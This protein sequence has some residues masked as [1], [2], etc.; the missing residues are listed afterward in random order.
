GPGD[1]IFGLTREGDRAGRLR[2]EALGEIL[3]KDGVARRVTFAELPGNPDSLPNRAYAY[4][5]KSLV[6]DRELAIK[7]MDDLL[8]LPAEERLALNAIAKY[9]RARL[10]M[11]LEDWN[12][13]DDAAAKERLTERGVFRSTQVY[14][15]FVDEEQR[16]KGLK[17]TECRSCQPGSPTRAR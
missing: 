1:V 12:R 15:M 11:S 2:L 3:N 16:G 10:K 4:Y 7:H 5:F 6:A 9:R 13:L 8:A 17:R 14:R